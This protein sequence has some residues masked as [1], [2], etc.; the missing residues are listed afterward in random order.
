MANNLRLSNAAASAAAGD[1]TSAGLAG[2]IGSGAKIKFYVGAQNTTPETAPAGTLL[3]TLT[4]SGSFGTASNGA[5]ET[6][7]I[8]S[9]AAAASGTPGSWMLFKS[10]GTTPIADGTVGLTTGYDANF[11]SVTWI[12]G[13]TVALSSLALTI[14]P[15]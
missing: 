8:G 1:G 14:P 5:T 2:Y 3:A 10:D 11:D 12:E 4:V 7:S 9:A 6:T 13:G 15:H